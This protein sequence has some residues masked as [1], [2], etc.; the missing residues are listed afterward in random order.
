[1]EEIERSYE[2][3]SRLY[4]PQHSK[5]RKASER[6]ER[7]KQA[8]EVLSDPE[9]RAEYDRSLRGGGAVGTRQSAVTRFIESRWGLPALAGIFGVVVLAAV[10]TA[11]LADD[12]GDG[13]AVLGSPTPTTDASPTAASTPPPVDGEEVTTDSGLTVITIEEG[14]GASPAMGDTVVV[15]YTGWLEEDG[16]QFDTGD[17]ISFTVGGVI[18]GWNEGLQLMREGGEARL[19][20]PSELAYGESGAPPRIPPN[21]NLIFDI[22]LIE[23]QSADGTP[24]PNGEEASS[25][26]PDETSEQESE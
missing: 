22:E 12:D 10:L 8:Y 23:V 17:G 19:I 18:E 4:D 11:L 15:N 9:R 3:L 24:A 14:A 7:I 25:P 21:S 2:R 26:S 13:E 6:W 16:S 1:M 5:K 20:I